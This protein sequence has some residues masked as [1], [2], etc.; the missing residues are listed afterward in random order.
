M[1]KKDRSQ[2]VQVT[3]IPAALNQCGRSWLPQSGNLP[4]SATSRGTIKH[5]VV[6][7]MTEPWVV[8]LQTESFHGKIPPLKRKQKVD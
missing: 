8:S 2:D 3:V 4:I 1:V 7:V 6:T 5:L